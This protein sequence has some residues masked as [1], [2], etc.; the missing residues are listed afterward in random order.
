MGRLPV[1]RYKKKRVVKDK[2][3]IFPA[4]VQCVQKYIVFNG[5]K[6]VF[7]PRHFKIIH[8]KAVIAIPQYPETVIFLLKVITP[9]EYQTGPCL[10]CT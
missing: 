2:K 9:S 8:F 7:L 5:E 4:S 1:S 3:C 6:V 10:L